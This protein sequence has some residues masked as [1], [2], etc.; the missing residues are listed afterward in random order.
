MIDEVLQMLSG[1]FFIG[2]SQL[3]QRLIGLWIALSTEYCLQRLRYD[4]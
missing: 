2:A 1:K 4:R 3:L